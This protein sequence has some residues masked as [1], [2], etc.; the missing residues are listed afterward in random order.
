MNNQT[1]VKLPELLTSSE[2]GDIVRALNTEK[3]KTLFV[4]GCVRDA[5]LGNEI[6]DVDIGTELHYIDV[7][8]ILKSKGIITLDVVKGYS[9]VRFSYEGI[10]VEITSLRNDVVTNGRQA[11]TTFTQS[12]RE[13]TA[14]RDFTINALY[15]D[16]NG[17]LI[18]YF[19]GYQDI[20]NGVVR[21]I[22]SPQFR[23]EED[24]FRILRYYR[25]KTLMK[26]FSSDSASEIC[27]A[28]SDRLKELSGYRVASEIFKILKFPN[29][30][31]VLKLMLRDH[32]LD[33]V[34]LHTESI[35]HFENLLKMEELL[36]TQ[37][38][39][40]VRLAALLHGSNN[41]RVNTTLL[42]DR[43]RLFRKEVL[44]LLITIEGESIKSSATQNQ[45]TGLL[46]H[47][48]KDNLLRMIFFAS[49]SAENQEELNDYIKMVHF[50]NE[51][52]DLP[53]F[54]LLHQDLQSIAMYSGDVYI[55]KYV[56][57]ARR[58]WQK[59][60]FRPKKAHIIKWL[61]KKI[62]YDIQNAK[63]RKQSM[64]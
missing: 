44:Q 10:D 40:I 35:D 27:R 50:V 21:F 33:A 6:C 48:G 5:I 43:W 59:H 16:I 1:I 29:P 8:K 55:S 15:C 38:S 49:L 11:L 23:I 34:G 13:D 7:I 24:V 22:G 56:R 53:K 20:L 3:A 37:S 61:E 60:D 28:Y 47:Y 62:E 45:I 30:L 2:L 58:W 19:G 41:I 46:T 12:W 39:H 52:I 42:C 57:M 54:P 9:S 17:N 64:V 32:I 25:L 36:G 26:D 31:P 18:D 51:A 4:G 63:E 14:R